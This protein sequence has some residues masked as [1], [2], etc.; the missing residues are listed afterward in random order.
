MDA[1]LRHGSHA[2]GLGG[3]LQPLAPAAVGELRH[4]ELALFQQV[5]VVAALHVA[6]LAHELVE[7]LAAL[8]VAHVDHHLAVGGQHHLGVLVLEAAEGGALLRGGPGV[9]RIDLDDVAGAVGLVGMPGDVEAFVGDGPGV[10]LVL[11]AHAVALE[12]G[13]HLDVRVA[14]REIVVEVLLA[15]EVGAPGG[16]AVAAVVPGAEAA[17]AGEVGSGLEQRVAT[18]RPG[19]LHRS[20]GRDPAVVRRV[21]DDGPLTGL[22]GDLQYGHAVAGLALAHVV[23]VG[24]LA[25]TLAAEDDAQVHVLVV[26]REH[27]P[28]AVVEQRHAVVVVAEGQLLAGAGAAGHLVEVRAARPQGIAPPGHHVPA[29]SL[30]NGDG[31]EAVGRHRLEAEAAGV[32]K[33]REGLQQAGA[34]D[35]RGRGKGGAAAQEPSP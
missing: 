25:R 29:V 24:G 7:E 27:V 1:D 30:G 10:A 15:R 9:Q 33:R 5:G 20:I 17:G 19:D 34:H 4:V 22:A 13:G 12:L 11:D 8:V 16:A 31:V 21:L 3:Q 2:G 14:G 32:G 23:G 26:D 28:A 18:G 35:E 6:S